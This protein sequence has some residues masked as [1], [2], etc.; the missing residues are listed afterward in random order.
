MSTENRVAEHYAAQGLL[1]RILSALQASGIDETAATADDLKPV[2]EFH[3]GGAAA[4]RAVLDPLSLTADMRLLDIGSGI[5]GAAR[6]I[7]AEY[8]ASVHGVDLT[9]DF[10]DAAR[11]LSALV[12]LSEK[13]TFEVGSALDLPIQPSSFN[14]ATLLHVGM[15]IPDKTVLMAQAARA[16]KPGGFFAVYDVM[17]MSDGPIEFP[18]PWASTAEGSFVEAPETYRQA[19][20]AAGFKIEAERNRRDAALEFFAKQR[21]RAATAGP[22]SIGIHLLMQNAAPKIAN[23]VAQLQSSRLAPVELILRKPD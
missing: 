7:A 2:D 17:R 21:E 3:I 5:G 22:P 19:A 1:E 20:T 13:T 8:G 10:V 15:N 4:T 11:A 23:M 12:G 18:V 9:P 6:L 16:L 14:G